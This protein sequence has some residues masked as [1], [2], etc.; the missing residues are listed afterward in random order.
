[1][2]T[3]AH[4]SKQNSDNYYLPYEETLKRLNEMIYETSR[5][6]YYFIQMD[7]IQTEQVPLILRRS[8]GMYKEEIHKKLKE[9]GYTIPDYKWSFEFGFSWE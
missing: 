3:P 9:C 4:I 2:I 6:G 8:I 1:M 5:S 7:L